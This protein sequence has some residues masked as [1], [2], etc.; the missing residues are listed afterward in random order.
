MLKVN[1]LDIATLLLRIAA[2]WIFIYAGYLKLLVLPRAGLTNFFAASG[3]PFP[4]YTG[5]AIGFLEFFGGIFLLVGFLTRPLGFIFTLEMLVAIIVVHL[6]EGYGAPLEVASLLFFVTLSI[7]IIGGGGL[8][9]DKLI[10]R[11]LNV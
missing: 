2:G 11:K 3:F 1:K 9:F 7:G 5:L 10:K 8:S 6:P 4:E